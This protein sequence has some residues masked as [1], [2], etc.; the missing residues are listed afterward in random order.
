MRRIVGSFGGVGFAPVGAGTWGSLAAL[1]IGYLLHWLGGFPLLA[2]ATVI[3][4][5]AGLWAAQ[6]EVGS[7][8]K[9]DPSWIVID[10]VVGMWI[11]LFPLSLGLWL[12]DAP[13]SLF[14]WPGWVSAF[15]IFRLLDIW[16]PGPVGWADRRRGAAG[17][18]LD[19]VIAGI[20]TALAVTVMAG[21]AH[22]WLA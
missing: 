21:I 3:A 4:F 19:D 14:P 22:G 16:K 10:E 13:A 11:A 12:N 2:I 20:L 18:M 1:V 17:V 6:H 15:V 9:F 5:A 8:G 7:P